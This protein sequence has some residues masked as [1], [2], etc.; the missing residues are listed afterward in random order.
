MEGTVT[1]GARPHVRV[2]DDIGTLSR[3]AADFFISCAG[4]SIET[5]GRFSV[6]LSGGSTPERLYSLLTVA[7]FREALSWERVHFFWSDE[8]CVPPDHTESNFRLAYDSLLSELSLPSPNIHRIH[9]EETPAEA[10][11]RYEEDIGDFFNGMPRF[12]LILLGIGID[13]HTASLFPGSP[14]LRETEKIALPV[15]LG[16]EKRDRVTLTLPVLN[17][18]RV[19]LFLASGGNKADVVSAV[20]E[21]GNRAC[22]PAGLVEPNS[23]EVI[24]MLDREAGSKLRRSSRGEG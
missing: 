17:N 20:L 6:V 7:P 14:A 5:E 22:C 21:G 19:V 3:A 23:G 2:F 4:R 1:V 11:A 9:G 15:R 12:D 8:R 13:G 16:Q 24:W 18:A 10:A